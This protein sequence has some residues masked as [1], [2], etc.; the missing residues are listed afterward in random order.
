M[1]PVFDTHPPPGLGGGKGAE[2]GGKEGGRK[3]KERRRGEGGK[4]ERFTPNHSQPKAT[5][6]TSHKESNQYN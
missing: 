6:S 1:F 3:G 5:H 2:G 4:G